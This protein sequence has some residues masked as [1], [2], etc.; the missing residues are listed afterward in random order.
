MATSDKLILVTEKSPAALHGSGPMVALIQAHKRPDAS[1]RVLF[2]R[3]RTNTT[4]GQQ[5]GLDIAAD[6]GLPALSVEL[7][8][9]SAF[10]NAFLA[11][12]AAVTG[13]QQTVLL[14]LAME[15]TNK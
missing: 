2:N 11:G 12:P 9:S 1:A 6:L 7:P 4:V 8:L 13:K 5:Q 3:V 15:V 14:K 10:E